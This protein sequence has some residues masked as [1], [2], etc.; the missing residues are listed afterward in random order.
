MPDFSDILSP[1]AAV[2]VVCTW[3]GAGQ[4][5]RTR[6]GMALVRATRSRSWGLTKAPT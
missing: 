4:A 2:E 3:V 6:E 5:S 1:T